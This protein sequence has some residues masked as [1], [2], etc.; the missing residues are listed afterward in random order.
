MGGSLAPRLERPIKTTLRRCWK[1]DIRSLRLILKGTMNKAVRM[2]PHIFRRRTKW[3][4]WA[5]LSASK[6]Q[7][8]LSRMKALLS[9]ILFSRMSDDDSVDKKPECLTTMLAVEAAKSARLKVIAT[10]PLRKRQCPVLI[11]VLVLCCAGSEE[12]RQIEI[13]I[14][15]LTYTSFWRIRWKHN[16]NW[17][18]TPKIE[19]QFLTPNFFFFDLDFV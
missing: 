6:A 7:A 11:L 4:S 15:I 1:R 18:D 9:E 16:K 14:V 10:M 13:I 3:K 8:C 2:A 19:Y 17:R 5:K 12:Q